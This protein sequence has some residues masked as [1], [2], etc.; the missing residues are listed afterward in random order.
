MDNNYIEHG[1]T[2]WYRMR[3][4]KMTASSFGKLM[5]KPR[6]KSR[7]W[8]VDGDALILRKAY[9]VFIDKYIYDQPFSPV[10]ANWGLRHE[11]TALDLLR[12]IN[13]N[14]KDLGLIASQE[15]SQIMAT[16]DG[17]VWDDENEI[18]RNLIQIKC[19]YNGKY[20]LEYKAKIIN[21]KDL[22]KKK[23]HYY[24]QV[25]GEMW[26]T[27]IYN[28]Y[29]I[30]FDPR[31]DK[32]AQL[33]IVPV[34]RDETD[35]DILRKKVLSAL[36]KRDEIVKELKNGTRKLPNYLMPGYNARADAFGHVVRLI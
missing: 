33:H 31:I 10:A 13:W 35:V 12:S 4:G 20:H 32:Y 36:D 18:I 24:W 9:E 25:L 27:N 21:G 28:S 17:A 16:P 3:L 30:S 22:K 19:P 5:A 2:Q 14:I 34:Q 11:K 1:T 8:S 6:D 26:V 23:S 7:E 15:N 29:F